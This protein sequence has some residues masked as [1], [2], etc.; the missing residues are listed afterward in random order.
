MPAARGT[1]PSALN[2]AAVINV[3]ST[4]NGLKCIDD[5]HGRPLRAV[6]LPDRRIV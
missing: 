3:V 1:R 4:A 2:L 6:G 5:R